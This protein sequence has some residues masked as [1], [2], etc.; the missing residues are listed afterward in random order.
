MQKVDGS[1]LADKYEDFHEPVARVYA[2]KEELAAD[3]GIYLESVDVSAS[4]GREPDMAIL[5][6]R[7]RRLPERNLT[8][9]EKKLAVGQAMEIKAGYGDKITRIFFGYLHE[10]EVCDLMQGY[11]EY[12]LLCLD[13]KGLMKK[14]SVFQTS[15]AQKIQ[16]TLDEILNTEKYKTFAD[17]REV[18]ALPKSMNQDCVIK[19]ET[20]YDWLCGLA[21]YLDYE[22]FCGRGSLIFR[23][24]GKGDML[25]TLS[26]K[27]GLLMARTRVSLAEQTGSVNVCSYNR[28]DVKIAAA[29]QW[30]GIT[31][32]FG[33]KITQVLQGC[34]HIMRDME[35]E[36]GEQAVYR[37]K[38]VMDR[39]ARQCSRME[40]V[41]I[42]IPEIS[43]GIYVKLQGETADSLKGTMYVDEVRHLLNGNG[44]RTVF[45][46]TRTK[47]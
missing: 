2:D 19:G 43:P 15:G 18:E 23:K 41:N 8:T 27:C 14:N 26:E 3:Q 47:G 33:Q 44:Y 45:K 39:A 24:A 32:P 12:T 6:Y 25:L 36:T 16:Q 29:A 10:I 13:V 4:S 9:F 30:T 21:E 20:H 46:G 5:V 34:T 35:L 11:V 17:K 1:S 22:F 37:A 31:Q 38:A 42:G 28:K 40:A 7:V